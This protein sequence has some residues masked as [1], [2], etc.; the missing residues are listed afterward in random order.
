MKYLEELNKL[1]GKRETLKSDSISALD[2]LNVKVKTLE[3]KMESAKKQ[4]FLNPS[5]EIEVLAD[6]AI[7]DYTVAQEEYTRKKEIMGQLK[8]EYLIEYTRE[9]LKEDIEQEYFNT[10]LQ[11]DIEEYEEIIIRA[12]DLNNRIRDKWGTLNQLTSRVAYSV[13]RMYLSNADREKCVGDISSF[14]VDL[15][16]DISKLDTSKLYSLKEISFPFSSIPKDELFRFS[17]DK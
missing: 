15:Y 1:A 7:K 4:Y 5:K 6:E 17:I 14:M 12:T 9:Q 8:E 11:K 10:G 16:R 13:N 2:G 3:K